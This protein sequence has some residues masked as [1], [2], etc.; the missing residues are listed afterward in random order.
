MISRMW[1]SFITD[2]DPNKSR[3]KS[4]GFLRVH[5]IAYTLAIP[6]NIVFD[7]NVTELAFTEPGIYRAAGI[8]YISNRFI[9]V[10]GR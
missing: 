6:Q 8:Q 2:L 7:A 4:F 10:Y 9:S 5:W 1:V 3:G